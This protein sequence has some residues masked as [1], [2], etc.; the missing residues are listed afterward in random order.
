MSNP[1]P[2]DGRLLGPSDPDY[3]TAGPPAPPYKPAHPLFYGCDLIVFTV[4]ATPELAGTVAKA[5]GV[6]AVRPAGW[7]PPDQGAVAVPWY[8]AGDEPIGRV[9]SIMQA[10]TPGDTPIGATV[11]AVTNLGVPPAAYVA[12]GARGTFV[13][14][15]LGDTG[16][17][18]NS[19]NTQSPKRQLWQARQDGWPAPLV[20]VFGAYDGQPFLDEVLHLLGEVDPDLRTL[21]FGL[22]L[23]LDALRDRDAAALLA[24]P[25]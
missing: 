9:A 15:Y 14:C 22:F 10:E 3:A 19:D 8:A 17:P 16:Q 1:D 6:L 5:G 12:A 25:R 13:E 21:S 11:A 18:I 23:G 7:P 20:P 4:T 2:R 24:R